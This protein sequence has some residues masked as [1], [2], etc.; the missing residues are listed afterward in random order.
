MTAPTHRLAAILYRVA[1]HGY[2]PLEFDD[3][4]DEF[5]AWVSEYDRGVWRAGAER[6]IRTLGLIAP[7]GE[8]VARVRDASGCFTNCAGPLEGYLGDANV[9]CDQ[10]AAKMRLAD[11]ILAQLG[12]AK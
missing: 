8:I 10:C 6:I 9:M 5:D 7:P 11:A 4:D 12:A 3:G 2:V 1:N